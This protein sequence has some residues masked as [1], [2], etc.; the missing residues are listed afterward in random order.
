MP[1]ASMVHLIEIGIVVFYSSPSS[2]PTSGYS[3]QLHELLF[4][5]N[6]P[7]AAVASFAGPFRQE[8]IY[9]QFI[10]EKND[11]KVKYSLFENDYQY[12]GIISIARNEP[13]TFET[14]SHKI[15]EQSP[16]LMGHLAWFTL[17]I[18][19]RLA[20]IYA[21][22][23]NFFIS[24]AEEAKTN[25]PYYFKNIFREL[26]GYLDLIINNLKI[27]SMQEPSILPHYQALT[28]YFDKIKEFLV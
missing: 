6:R 17:A 15:F 12:S 18:V 23:E 10:P 2:T 22:F 11:D 28:Y 19:K 25:D 16:I 21:D 1:V 26:L 14:V 5:R 4:G 27:L 3:K 7:F 13:C 8:V 9:Y 20:G 24:Q